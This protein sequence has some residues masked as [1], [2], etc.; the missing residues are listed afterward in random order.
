MAIRIEDVTLSPNPVP[1]HG[2]LVRAVCRI[3][4]DAP[5][6]SV[7]AYPPMGDSISFYKR[8]EREFIVEE[9]LPPDSMPGAY[10]VPVVATDEMGDT[11]RKIVTVTIE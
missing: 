2:G 8:S 7:V 9:Y 4:S 10:D 11:A 5:V 3:A 6:K 1:S